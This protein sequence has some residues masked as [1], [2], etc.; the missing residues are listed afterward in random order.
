MYITTK[1]K[2]LV[3]TIEAKSS[4]ITIQQ[5]LNTTTAKTTSK[6]TEAGSH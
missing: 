6:P 2:N 5:L 1:A 4:E 3:A